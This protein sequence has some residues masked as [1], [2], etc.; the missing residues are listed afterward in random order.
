MP[1]TSMPNTPMPD[2]KMSDVKPGG[3]SRPGVAGPAKTPASK[4]LQRID[5]ALARIE[6]AVARDS[7]PKSDNAAAM[8]QLRQRHGALRIATEGALAQIDA[9]IT[10]WDAATTRADGQP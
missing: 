6:A 2:A 3:D 7:G 5:A 9:L 1:D 8:E 10:T 4:A